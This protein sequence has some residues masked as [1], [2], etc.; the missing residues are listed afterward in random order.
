MRQT[1][2]APDAMPIVGGRIVRLRKVSLVLRRCSE[3]LYLVIERRKSCQDPTQSKMR[4]LEFVN[5]P[6]RLQRNA[7]DVLAGGVE[8]T[9][10]SLLSGLARRLGR[11]NL[12]GLDLL[13]IGCG[14]RFTQTLI[15]RD[16]PFASYT[17]VEVSRPIVECGTRGRARVAPTNRQH[18]IRHPPDIAT[19]ESDTLAQ[20]DPD[21]VARQFLRRPI[22]A[23]RDPA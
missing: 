19:G 15:N 10:E 5:V 3:G 16:L 7:P 21:P 17:G 18:P 1:L 22:I 12:A 4:R 2:A 14:V 8:Q 23:T 20:H 9:G 6:D 13:D 11:A